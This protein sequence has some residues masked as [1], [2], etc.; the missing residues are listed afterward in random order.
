MRFILRYK[1]SN[2]VYA[3]GKM[4]WHISCISGYNR[5]MLSASRLVASLPICGLGEQ[6]HFFPTIGSTN[7]QAL[8]LARQGA[9]H[10]TLVVA[11]EQTAGRGRA[12]RHWVTPPNSALALSLVL[13]PVGLPTEAVGGMTVIGALAVAEAL[14]GIGVE[15]QIK[16]PNDVLLSGRKVAGVLVE[17]SWMGNEIEY[18]VLGIGVNMRPEAVPPAAEVDYPATCVEDTVGKHVE[19]TALLLS[20]VEGVGRWYPHLGR[21][22]LSEAWNSRL[23][24]QGQEVLVVGGTEQEIVGRVLGLSTDGRLRLASAAGEILEISAGDVHLRPVDMDAK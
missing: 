20:I 5:N 9:P 12:G 10:G 3:F 2:R 7:D 13:R 17:G 16:W 24:F 15:A 19:R 4:S 6:F 18:A 8:E 14:E 22:A 23:A 1:N 21:S 11:D